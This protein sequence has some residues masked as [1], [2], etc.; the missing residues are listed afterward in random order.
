MRGQEG[1]LGTIGPMARSVRDLE[2]F[3]T[4]LLAARPWDIDQGC[5]KMPW[6]RNEVV[7]K[8]GKVPRVG[9]MWEDGVVRP[10]PPMRRAMKVVVEKLRANGLEVGD[11]PP[12]KSEEAWEI[13]VSPR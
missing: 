10:Q 12:F 8:G 4:T 5:F 6:R 13:T 2:L 11:Y 1:V 3:I 9:V 7:F